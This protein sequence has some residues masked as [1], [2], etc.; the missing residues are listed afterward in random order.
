VKVHTSL[1]QVGHD[2]NS[3]TY[4]LLWRPLHQKRLLTKEPPNRSSP[5]QQIA[6]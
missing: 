1:L 5:M 3:L 2:F 6:Y 4:T